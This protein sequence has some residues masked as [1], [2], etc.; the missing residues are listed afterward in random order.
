MRE[1]KCLV[2]FVGKILHGQICCKCTTR[3]ARR[4]TN[5]QNKEYEI[6]QSEIKEFDEINTFQSKFATFK[7]N[8]CSKFCPA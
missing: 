2:L 8:A 4:I 1:G 6:L 5:K 3:N 7:E